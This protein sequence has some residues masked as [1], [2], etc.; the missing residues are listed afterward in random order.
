[1][2]EF[3]T[4]FDNPVKS[5][6]LE[7]QYKASDTAIDIKKIFRI[8]LNDQQF[9]SQQY[10]EEEVEKV[11]K[12]QDLLHQIYGK[13]QLLGISQKELASE[14]PACFTNLITSPNCY[15]FGIQRTQA[16]TDNKN[17][18]FLTSLNILLYPELTK[19]KYGILFSANDQLL[20]HLI[21]RIKRNYR[22][23]RIKNTKEMQKTNLKIIE[24]L[25][26]GIIVP[27]MVQYVSDIFEVNIL[28]FDFNA[29]TTEFYWPYSEQFPYFNLYKKLLVFYRDK[30]FFEPIINKNAWGTNKIYPRILTNM[31]DI[32]F[33][34]KINLSLLQYEQLTSPDFAVSNID[35]A[36]IN[37]N[38]PMDITL[39]P[40]M[41]AKQSMIKK[42]SF[43]KFQRKY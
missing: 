22:I 8:I 11:K 15:R 35:Y 26:S 28:V 31:N 43:K 19:E 30:E 36:I 7:M 42:R 34:R 6:S 14:F 33:Q 12:K 40:G 39:A 24:L 16:G 10:E 23:D 20:S 41:N 27:Q 25:Q 38:V 32:V 13:T 21:E 4:L 18:S 5:L 2:D 3:K 17:I 9:L 37:A 29:T 1:M